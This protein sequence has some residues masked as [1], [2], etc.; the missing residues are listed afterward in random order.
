MC[1]LC[2]HVHIVI[3]IF[4][5]LTS[6]IY[7]V[8]L[9]LQLLMPLMVNLSSWFP[10]SFSTVPP[11]LP[12]TFI[13]LL[14]SDFTLPFVH[15]HSVHHIP[16]LFFSVTTSIWTLWVS[17]SWLLT[18]KRWTLSAAL[19]MKQKINHRFFIHETKMLIL[20]CWGIGIFMYKWL[21]GSSSWLENIQINQGRRQLLGGL[22]LGV[23]LPSLPRCL[24]QNQ[25]FAFVNENRW[26][27]FCFMIDKLQVA[28]W[29]P[30][31]AP[32]EVDGNLD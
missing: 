16:M 23:S 17:Q 31:F 1:L 13:F 12:L 25:H 14:L 11:S 2:I 22:R 24:Y 10:H 7:L 27:I 6:P 30:T 26:L 29:H 21:F 28:S 15:Q 8:D 3:R 32:P 9:C 4:I 20:I 5:L 19:E 18:A